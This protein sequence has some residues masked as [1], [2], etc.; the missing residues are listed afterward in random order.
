MPKT[1]NRGLALLGETR[2]VGGYTI[3]L[4]EEDR[5]RMVTRC[6]G[7]SVPA[8]AAVGF[9]KGCK[10][11]KTN[12]GI[13]TTEYTNV[14]SASSADFDV[15]ASFPSSPDVIGNM[16]WAKETA[17]TDTVTASTTNATAGGSLARVGGAGVTT[18]AGGAVSMTGGVGGNDAVGGAAS[19][20]GGAAGGGNRAGGAALVTGGAGAGS[21]AGGA[22][23]GTGGVGGATG[24]GGAVGL[25]GGAGGA[26]SGAGGAV[27][28]TAGAASSGNSVGGAAGV[29]GGL[30]KGTSAGGAVTLTSGAASNGTGV[31]PGASGAI[32]LQVGAAGTAT[33]GTAGAGGTL[34]LLGANGGASTGASS[35]A[36]NGSGIVITAGDGGASSGGSDTAGNGGNITQTPG[37]AGAGA[38]SGRY[39]AIFQRGTVV[40]KFTVTAKT[41]SATISAAELLGGIITGNQG[42]GG[43]ATYTL[44]TGTQL[45]A[46][47]PFQLATGDVVEFSVINLSTVDAEDIT[48][49]GDTGT[50]MKGNVVISAYSAEGRD[51]S[52]LFRAIKTGS[53]TFDVYRIA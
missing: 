48:I 16:T 49:A 20:V 33:T 47:L 7:A 46:A 24:D 41:T 28:L 5:D 2:I 45:A 12:G 8:D 11:I 23:T 51:S 52:G 18:G 42:A 53:N 26:T 43:A 14:G 1:L 15:T 38:T 9:A 40:R 29:T 37:A 21:A 10:F 17:H 35:Q 39:G 34:S 32:T 50:T 4:L 22:V 31:S 30:G 3:T 13:S 36:G 19:L 6:S 27:A 25:T 44:P